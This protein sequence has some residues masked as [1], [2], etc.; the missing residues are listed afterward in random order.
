MLWWHAKN[1][2]QAA[3]WRSTVTLSE[4]FYAEVIEHPIPV[5]LRALKA[6]KKSPMAL[7]L[8]CWLTYRASYAK[9]PSTIPWAALAMQFGSDYARLRDFKASFLAELRKVAT[10]YAGAQFEITDAGLVVKPSLPHIARK[11]AP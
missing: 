1:P 8:Y 4:Q 3:L 7:D 5:D 11:D 10:V 2:E 6:L 9:T